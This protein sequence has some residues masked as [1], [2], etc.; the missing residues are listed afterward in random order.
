M[1]RLM[2]GDSK[3]GREVKVCRKIIGIW[4]GIKGGMKLEDYCMIVPET[5]L[6]DGTASDDPNMALD[7]VSADSVAKEF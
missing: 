6:A 5:L 3:R 1:S 4:A 2:V 7:I